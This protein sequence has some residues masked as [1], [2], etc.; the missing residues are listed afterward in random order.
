MTPEYLGISGFAKHAGLADSTINSYL[1]KGMLPTPDIVYIARAGSRPAWTID[2]V[3]RWMNNR[4]G[5]GR[6]Y[7]S[8]KRHPSNNS[9]KESIG[10]TSFASIPTH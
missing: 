1:R 3:E 6:R 5:R 10:Q 9:M 8:M 2:T 4:P 7:A